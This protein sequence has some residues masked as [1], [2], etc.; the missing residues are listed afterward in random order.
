MKNI[1]LTDVCLA[2]LLTS[3]LTSCDFS[4]NNLP[5]DS[6]NENTINKTPKVTSKPVEPVNLSLTPEMLEQLEQQEKDFLVTDDTLPIST[7]RTSKESG[8]NISG[9]LHLDDDK[10]DYLDAVEGAEIQIEGKFK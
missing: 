3:L 8:L 9:K 5:G 10:E 7:Q 1:C 2:L 6:D 4:D